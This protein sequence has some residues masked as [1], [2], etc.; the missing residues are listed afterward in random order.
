LKEGVVLPYTQG[1]RRISKEEAEI[2]EKYVRDNLAKGWIIPSS[3]KYASP[4]LFVRK[5]NRALRLYV[6]YRGLNKVTKKD[7]YL[8]L[9]IDKTIARVIKARYYTKFDIE[10]TFNNLYIATDKDA[11]LTTFATRYGNYKS[12]VLLFGLSVGPAYF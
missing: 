8:L 7:S 9:L 2:V 1:L 4:I 10:A 11:D 3:F 12:L 6:D 5:A